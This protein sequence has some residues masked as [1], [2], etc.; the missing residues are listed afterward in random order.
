MK[1]EVIIPFTVRHTINSF[2]DMC[3]NIEHITYFLDGT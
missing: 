3:R 2:I 1:K